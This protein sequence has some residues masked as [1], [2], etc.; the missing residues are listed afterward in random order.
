MK[1]LTGWTSDNV[2]A[3][4]YFILWK[5]LNFHRAVELLRGSRIGMKRR[6]AKSVTVIRQI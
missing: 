5:E 4:K 6:A 3:R 1:F 2:A